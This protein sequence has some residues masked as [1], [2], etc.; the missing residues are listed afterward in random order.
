MSVC[1]YFGAEEIWEEREQDSVLYHRVLAKETQDVVL[2]SRTPLPVYWLYLHS[3]RD[4]PDDSRRFIPKFMAG[5]LESKSL[6]N[7]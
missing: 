4:F 2:F 6:K 5:F 1:I 7:V 3:L